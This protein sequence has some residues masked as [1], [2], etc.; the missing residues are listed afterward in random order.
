MMDRTTGLEGIALRAERA[1][2]VASIH[3]VV[4]EA[5]RDM[6]HAEGDEAD[7]VDHLRNQGALTVSIVAE[8]AD[9]IIGHIAFSP[10]MASE[11][12]WF[13]LGPLAVVPEWQG[14]GVGSALVRLGLQAL[15]AMQASGCIL[16]GHPEYYSRLGFV[17]AP[18]LAPPGQP[19][20]YFFIHPLG[21]KL[22]LEPVDFHPLF[23]SL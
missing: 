12:R 8:A 1:S 23:R 11:G 19:A 3:H 6:E 4:E 14:K 18:D 7:L 22:P 5:F 10:A 13:A 2:D 16:V 21:G 20:E 15:E 9:Q 17:P